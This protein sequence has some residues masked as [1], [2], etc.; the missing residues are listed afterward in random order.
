MTRTGLAWQSKLV[1]LAVLPATAADV[2]LQTEWWSRQ[3]APVA[4]WTIGLSTLLGLITWKTRA[5]TPMASIT[6][7]IITA[8]LI[9]STTRYPYEPWH[10]ALVPVLTVSVLAFA[11]TRVGH[12]KKERLGT[13][14]KHGGR[15][16]A[17]IASNLGIAA[18]IA[19]EMAESW[20]P[21]SVRVSQLAPLQNPLFTVALAA[22]AEAAADTVSSELGQVFGGAP[23]MITTFRR[24]EPGTDGAITWTGSL[25]GVL[26]SAIV[27]ATGTAALGGDTAMFAIGA[28]G[29]VFGLFFDSLLGATLENAGKL[30]NDAVNFLSTASSAG[31][32][33]AVL[34]FWR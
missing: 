21:D 14:E 33:V 12:S 34:A 24:A 7:A 25:A 6:G 28:S 4:L 30:N 1:L 29:G 9:F 26:A 27:A 2:A 23:R 13:G 10:S 22:L 15:S 32:A 16:S 18:L 3:Q 17:Q 11:F 31:F 8:S 5:A 20:M 19:T